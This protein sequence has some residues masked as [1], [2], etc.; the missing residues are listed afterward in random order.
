[1]AL[2]PRA[3]IAISATKTD[4]SP[5]KLTAAAVPKGKAAN[6]QM[7]PRPGPE[8]RIARQRKSAK[9]V[10]AV[11][12]MPFAACRLA[13]ASVH[14]L[15][16]YHTIID[17]D[18]V[19]ARQLN[20]QKLNSCLA[21]RDEGIGTVKA[22]LV[23]IVIAPMQIDFILSDR[24]ITHL[25]IAIIRIKTKDV[26]M[27]T[28]IFVSGATHITVEHVIA[29]ASDQLIHAVLTDEC[30]VAYAAHEGVIVGTTPEVIE[31]ALPLEQVVA[32]ISTKLVGT[33][34]GGDEVISIAAAGLARVSVEIDRIIAPFAI[35]ID[36]VG[37][38][39]A[40]K[41]PEIQEIFVFIAL[42]IG[43]LW[44][45]ATLLISKNSAEAILPNGRSRL[46]VNHALRNPKLRSRHG[47]PKEILEQIMNKFELNSLLLR[48]T[49]P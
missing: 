26:A 40:G 47:K 41:S 38:S 18:N 30:V 16:E 3:I 35:Y 14:V 11:R 48:D 37:R 5:E 44:H 8:T 7:I 13:I 6:T 42:E 24:E 45:S 15:L 34:V 43:E 22:E 17:F 23:S 33:M 29:V 46:D 39:V 32:R 2:T 4:P 25:V 31:P 12:Y 10:V 49:Q 20:T 21:I 36:L 27:R 9:G 19:F 28:P 1:M